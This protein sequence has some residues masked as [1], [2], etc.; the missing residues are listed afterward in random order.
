MGKYSAQ[1]NGLV[2]A[3][4]KSVRMGRDK[5]AIQWYS[6]E[7]QYHLA[8]VLNVLCEEV[9]ISCKEIADHYNLLEYKFLPD[10]VKEAGPLGAILTALQKEPGKAWLVVA[11]DL[12]LVNIATLEYLIKNRDTTSIATTFESPFD[13]LPEPL[14]TIWEADSLETL[15]SFYSRGITCP[16]KVLINSNVKILKVPDPST[17]MNVNDPAE[18]TMVRHI[19]SKQTSCN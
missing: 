3:G 9:T 12:P 10:A 11:C 2:L 17:L 8:D 5:A 16:R 14:V 1:L 6:K 18:A 4:G 15:R 19:I 13:G 7:Q